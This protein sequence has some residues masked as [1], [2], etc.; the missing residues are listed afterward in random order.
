MSHKLKAIS[1]FY[2][3]IAIKSALINQPSLF[4]HNVH[5]GLVITAFTAISAVNSN[6]Q[7]KLNPI[8]TMLMQ[9]CNEDVRKC[10]WASRQSINLPS[11]QIKPSRSCIFNPYVGGLD[12]PT[13]LDFAVF[14]NLVFGYM[15]GFEDNL[16]AAIHPV[17][18]DWLKRVSEH[19]PS[20]PTLASD[21]MHI[22]SLTKALA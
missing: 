3:Q 18:K 9:S 14:P 7:S 13:M 8:T 5:Q 17:I 6:G 21:E 11:I 19:L 22:N 1:P 10:V 20:N 2:H 16:S 15:Y 12:Q 4:I